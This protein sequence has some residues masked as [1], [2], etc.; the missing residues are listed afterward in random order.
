MKNKTVLITGCNSGIGNLTAK[1]FHRNGWN[2]VATMRSAEKGTEF[3]EMDNVLVE[4]LDVT[5]ENSID[6]AVAH[7]L[8][9]FG[10]IDALINNS[11]YGG[12]G[13]F[14]QFSHADILKMFDTNVFGTM[15]VT[16]AVLPIMRRQKSGMIINITSTA[17][18]AGLPCTSVYCASKYAIEGWSEGLA[19]ECKPFNIKVKTIRPGAF[20]THFSAAT[21]NHLN[22][23]DD[24]L[25][26]LANN[27]LTHL[28]RL[29]KQDDKGGNPQDVADIIYRCATEDMPTHNLIGSDAALM[30]NM[31]NSMPHQD[32]LDLMEKTLLP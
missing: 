12:Y 11:G 9:R 16:K 19:I 23:G 30:A 4:R 22:S 5:D 20:S 29:R 14:E 24:E 15:R 10:R 26:Q 6:L 8:K 21:D 17:A 28:S 32:F 31:K 1:T 2:L 25:R 18:L 27:I 7:T 3:V 13:L